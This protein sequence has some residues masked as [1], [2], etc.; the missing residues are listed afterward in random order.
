MMQKGRGLAGKGIVMRLIMM[1]AVMLALGV[2]S[3]PAMEGFLLDNLVKTCRVAVIH[4]DRVAAGAAPSAGD[5]PDAHFCM[6]FM[7]A[8]ISVVAGQKKACGVEEQKSPLEIVRR[9]LRHVDDTKPPGTIMAYPIV[10]AFFLK[11]Y[12]CPT[13]IYN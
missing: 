5:L 13:R 8:A 6:G 7:A 10:E 4:G 3:A 9:F 2:G 1:V 12:P 11:T